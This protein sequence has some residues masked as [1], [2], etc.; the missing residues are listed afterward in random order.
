[1]DGGD[2]DGDPECFA[3]YAFNIFEVW[4]LVWLQALMKSKTDYVIIPF[5][6]NT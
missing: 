3:L 4:V 1:M 2:P 6:K 5:G